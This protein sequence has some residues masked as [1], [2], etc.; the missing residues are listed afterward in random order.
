VGLLERVAV[1][2]RG[3]VRNDVDM[4]LNDY[5]LPSMGQFGYGGS[6]YPYGLNMTGGAERVAEI[7]KTLPGYAAALRNCPPAFAA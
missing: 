5:L 6:S 3:E 7:Q 1:A 2:R 4:W